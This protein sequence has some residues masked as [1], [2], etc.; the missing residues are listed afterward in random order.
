MASFS[1][2]LPVSKSNAVAKTVTKKFTGNSFVKSGAPVPKKAT[3]TQIQTL[4]NKETEMFDL[5]SKIDCEVCDIVAIDEQIKRRL[6]SKISTVPDLRKDLSELLWIINNSPDQVDQIQAKSEMDILKRRIQDIEGGFDLALYIFRSSAIVEEY[7]K[8]VSQTRTNAFVKVESLKDDRLTSRKN[9]L[10]LQFLRV[11]KDHVNLGNFKQKAQKEV[12]S[13]CGGSSFTVCEDSSSMVCTCGNKVEMLDDTPT[14]KDSERVNMSSRYTYTCR[15]HFI[16]AMNRFEGKQNTEIGEDVISTLKREMTRH[17]LTEE[18]VTKDHIYMFLSENKLSD[19][20]ADI[21]LILFIIA[22]ILP[23]DIT[24][25]KTELLEMF[26]QLEESYREVK[27]DNRLNSLNVNWKLYK[28]LQLVDFPC[29]KDDFFCLKTPTKQGEHEEKWRDMIDYL[30]SK[31]PTAVT[32]FGKPRW[33]HTR[34]I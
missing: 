6:I 10:I 25:Y 26:D 28:L 16:E 19:Y 12:C 22:G 34:T 20:Y 5:N 23:P 32:S 8:I 17:A 11:S 14:F 30:R 2:Y 24:D 9:Q 29:K 27:D 1:Q 4:K 21:N 15:G 3:P 13:N 33:R 31:Y 18:T 7:K